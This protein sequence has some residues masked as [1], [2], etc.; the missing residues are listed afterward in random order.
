MELKNLLTLVIDDDVYKSFD[1]RRA[2]KNCGI[3][4]IVIVRDQKTAFELLHEH[5][6][7]KTPFGLVVSDMHYPLEAGREAD[8]EA[9]FQF[10]ERAKE[11]GFILPVILCSSV[12]YSG[13]GM[14]ILGAVW[15]SKTRDLTQDFRNVLQKLEK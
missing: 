7:E 12:R 10:V 1:I 2:L 14:G 8:K 6:K 11:E 13:N 3:V 9:G 4:D 5:Q 15:Y